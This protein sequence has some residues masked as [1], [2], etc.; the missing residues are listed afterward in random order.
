MFPVPSPATDGAGHN[1]ARARS[2]PTR[3]IAHKAFVGLL[4]QRRIAPHTARIENRATLGLDARTTRHPGYAVSQRKRKRIEEIFGW[5]KTAGG[6]RKTRLI[7]QTK[8][9]LAAYLVGA[10]YNS[11]R[12]ARL[13]TASG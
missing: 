1:R 6:L 2:A 4:R 11:L 5:M 10:A 12:M 9:Q 3:V 8:I 13:Q 7:G